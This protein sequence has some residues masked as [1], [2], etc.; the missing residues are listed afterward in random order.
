MHEYC[1]SGSLDQIMVNNQFETQE[2][3][4][5]CFNDILQGLSHLISIGLMHRDIKP[6]NVVYDGYNYKIID[7]ETV[8]HIED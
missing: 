6:G 1:S 5:K 3:I 7:F 2:S 8:K 4:I